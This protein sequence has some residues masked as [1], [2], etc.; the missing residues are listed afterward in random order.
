MTRKLNQA[1]Q[2]LKSMIHRLLLRSPQWVECNLCGWRGSRF[3]DDS[4]HR[5]AMC[6]RCFAKVRHRLTAAA[7]QYLENF[8]PQA[9]LENKKILHIAPEKNFARFLRRYAG[10]Y[11][12][13]D[14]NRKKVDLHL[15]ISNMDAVENDSYDLMVACD[16]LEHVPDDAA[17][18]REMH[19]I[20]HPGGYVVLTVPQKD[21]LEKTLE[22]PATTTPRER[23]QRFGQ[24]DHLRI[25]GA[26]FAQRMTKAGFEVTAVDESFFPPEV[27]KTH[28]L[29]PPHPSQHPLA[30]NHR[31]IYFGKK[32]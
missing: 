24:A 26:D 15:D 14:L 12:T 18:L 27:V 7:F 5:H 6:P 21:K 16:V 8:S 25:Y 30:T 29:L 11:V 13:A 3:A 22:D 20:L 19:R 2:R 1:A 32:H 4:W 23:K 31:K 10:K 28:V 17:A 9:L